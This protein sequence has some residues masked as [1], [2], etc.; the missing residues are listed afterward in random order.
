MASI[1][2]GTIGA[3]A[4]AL[5]RRATFAAQ[6]MKRSLAKQEPQPE[7]NDGQERF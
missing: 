5:A 6:D 2:C 1:R 3:M 7:G 4:A